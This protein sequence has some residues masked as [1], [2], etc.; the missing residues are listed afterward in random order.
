MEKRT[1]TAEDQF[2]DLMVVRQNLEPWEVGKEAC[3]LYELERMERWL[4][5][6][7]ETGLL[8]VAKVHGTDRDGD[9]T[10]DLKGL[11]VRLPEGGQVSIFLV[12]D[13]IR[14]DS[15][16][17]VVAEYKGKWVSIAKYDTEHP[18]PFDKDVF[19]RMLVD[20]IQSEH[21]IERNHLVPR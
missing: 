14:L 10:D 11:K 13:A 18:E 8:T 5:P 15:K 7:H 2:V 17:A 4:K 9:P 12:S 3:L 21:G 16:L 6:H 19:F 1:K 20:H